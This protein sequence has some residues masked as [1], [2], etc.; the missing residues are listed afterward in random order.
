MI[1]SERGRAGK[2]IPCEM[3]SRERVAM[4]GGGGGGTSL[5]L[6]TW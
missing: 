1:S 3:F 4:Q 6:V 5:G 2:S